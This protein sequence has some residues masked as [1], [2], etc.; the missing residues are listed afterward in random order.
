MDINRGR[1]RV[2]CGLEEEYQVT[3]ISKA[4]IYVLK[5]MN[6]KRT[7]PS[8]DIDHVQEGRGPQNP[9]IQS[10]TDMIEGFANLASA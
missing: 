10:R 7:T 8:F 3:R 2:R 9:F 1:N 4:I 5:G 6:Q